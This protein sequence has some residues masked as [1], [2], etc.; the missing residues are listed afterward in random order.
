[1]WP[2]QSPLLALLLSAWS[3]MQPAPPAV[4][5]RWGGVL[6][7]ALGRVLSRQLRRS[8]SNPTLVH[9]VIGAAG[10]IE[11]REHA[12]GVAEA[13]GTGRGLA[14]YPSNRR[15]HAAPARHLADAYRA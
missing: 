2:C 9:V 8:R 7:C 15:R 13:S 14:R 1:M 3:E 4:V 10:L 12:V 6:G 11:A 5:R